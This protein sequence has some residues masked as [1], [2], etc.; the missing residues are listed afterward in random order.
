MKD[1]YGRYLWEPSLI[2]GAPDSILNKP[3]YTDPYIPATGLAA[4]SILFG[5][6]AAYFVRVVNGIR[7]EQSLDYA[8][9]T[10]LVT[11]RCLVRGDGILVDQTGAV[12]HFAGGAT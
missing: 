2:V 6:L 11:F 4:K 8:F 5:D 10:D 12:K 9:N 1:S 3:V 7:F